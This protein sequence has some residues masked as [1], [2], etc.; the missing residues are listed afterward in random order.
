MRDSALPG[1]AVGFFDGVHCGH[2]A[3][4]DGV[5]AVLTFRNHPLTVLCPA[6]APRLIMTADE[7]LAALRAAGVRQVRALE[8]TPALAQLSPAEFC[9]QYLQGHAIRCG[10]NWRFGRAGAGDAEFARRQGVP[11]EVVPYAEWQGERVSSSRIRAA[12]EGGELEA[13]AAMLG[14][15][16][17]LTGRGFAGKGLGAALG[18]PTVNLQPENLALKLRPGVYAVEAAGVKGI[19][20]F[21]VAP[22]MGERAWPEPVM[23]IHFLA[24]PPRPEPGLRVRL[25]QFLRSERK[26]ASVDELKAQ[27]A[28]DCAKIAL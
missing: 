15:P 20:N 10:E 16:F 14:R 1:L 25:L 19:A 28:E 27:I 7:R 13:A 26:F 21:G 8:F 2:R 5:D 24:S 17:E 6:R 23:E 22:T 11:V 18:F 4:L 12:I 9:R 3:I